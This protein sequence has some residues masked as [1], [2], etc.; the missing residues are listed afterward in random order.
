MAVVH[1]NNI[2][3]FIA[4]IAVSGNEVIVDNDLDAQDWTAAETAIRC[5]TITGNDHSI[6]NIQH[7]AT[8]NLF[9]FEA[10]CTINNLNF[11]NFI[12]FNN[13]DA[14][15]FHGRNYTGTFNNCK[16]QGRFYNL[17]Y[18]R[19]KFNRCAFTFDN[20]L[21]YAHWTDSP[22]A[23]A[24]AWSECYVD[25]KMQTSNA[26]PVFS[27]YD[28]AVLQNCYFKGEL[29]ATTAYGVLAFNMRNC[30]VNVQ[31]IGTVTTPLNSQPT[32]L[33][34]LYNTDKIGS[35]TISER[36]NMIGLTDSQLKNPAAVVA[37][38]FPLVT[39]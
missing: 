25:F 17:A 4:A 35:V 14:A 26:S 10:N 12:C 18:R 28:A 36:A 31:L 15:T 16:F 1:V 3:D 39:S 33:I 7:I 2:T 22:N 13:S 29:T 20:G 30:V 5:T 11:L 8:G 24:A 32:S 21:H 23:S 37:T 27:G 19:V 38:G 6:Y 9:S 34:S